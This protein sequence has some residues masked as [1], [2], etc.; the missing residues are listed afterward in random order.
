MTCSDDPGSGGTE[1]R[2]WWTI[3]AA[4]RMFQNLFFKI[5]FFLYLRCNSYAIKLIVLK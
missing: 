4:G 5:L 3:G 2:E 1:G